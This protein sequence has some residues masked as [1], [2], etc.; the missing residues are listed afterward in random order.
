MILDLELEQVSISDAPPCKDADGQHRPVVLVVDDEQVIADTLAVI[1]SRNGFASM[2]AYSA[3]EALEL[4]SVVPPEVLVSDVVMPGMNGI[5]LAITMEGKVPDCKVLLFSGQASTLDL[6][7]EAREKG[8]NFLALTKPV[9]PTT[10]IECITRC[11]K[12]A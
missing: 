10:L 1:L 12:E 9:H 11:L 5:E 3:E 8:H 4:A 6:M 2:A 7:V